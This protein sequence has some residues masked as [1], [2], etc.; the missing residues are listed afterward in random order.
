MCMPIRVVDELELVDIDQGQSKRFIRLA[1]LVQGT[2]DLLL[3]ST[4]V[5]KG[6]QVID[7]SGAFEL[8][9]LE[10]GSLVQLTL[11]RKHFPEEHI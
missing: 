8:G 9:E 5:A 7:Q 4:V 2:R 11:I 6:S 10:A 1:C 3:I